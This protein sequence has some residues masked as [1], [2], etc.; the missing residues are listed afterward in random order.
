MLMLTPSGRIAYINRF[1]IR[2]HS[3]NLYYPPPGA[4]TILFDFASGRH[5]LC[6]CFYLLLPRWYFT[7]LDVMYGRVIYAPLFDFRACSLCFY[8]VLPG[9]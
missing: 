1:G 8:I 4:Y 5:S 7:I 6:L 3:W 2:T 9:V